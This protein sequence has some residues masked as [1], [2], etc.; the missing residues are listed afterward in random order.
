MPSPPSGSGA[1]RENAEWDM[2]IL[3]RQPRAVCGQGLPPLKAGTR[4]RGE[5]CPHTQGNS[6]PFSKPFLLFPRQGA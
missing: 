4:E 6:L 2:D 3:E 1:C 5:S